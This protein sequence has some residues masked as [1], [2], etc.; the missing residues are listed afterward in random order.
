[1]TGYYDPAPPVRCHWALNA[2]LGTGQTPAG[3]SPMAIASNV[4]ATMLSRGFS[5]VEARD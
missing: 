2:P 4:S 3:L 1:M 5:F